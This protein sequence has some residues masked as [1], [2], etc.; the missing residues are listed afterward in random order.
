MNVRQILHALVGGLQVHVVQNTAQ[1][2]AGVERVVVRED[3]PAR[4]ELEELLQAAEFLLELGGEVR[5][6]GDLCEHFA[7]FAHG[8]HLLLLQDLGA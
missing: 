6:G 1:C 7:D 5:R 2:D 3:K 4:E 8:L